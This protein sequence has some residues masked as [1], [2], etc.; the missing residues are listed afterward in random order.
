MEYFFSLI[1]IILTCVKSFHYN[2]FSNFGTMKE[3][4][5]FSLTLSPSFRNKMKVAVVKHGKITIKIFILLNNFF[6]K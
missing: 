1:F 2:E 3:I 4:F 5:V 6:F